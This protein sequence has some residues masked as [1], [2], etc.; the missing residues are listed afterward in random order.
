MNVAFCL[1][2]AALAV[3]LALT[4]LPEAAKSGYSEAAENAACCSCWARGCW[5]AGSWPEPNASISDCPSTSSSLCLRRP[6]RAGPERKLPGVFPTRF[7]RIDDWGAAA[8]GADGAGWTS[9]SP[10][11]AVNLGRDSDE[12]PGAGF[13]PDDPTVTLTVLTGTTG[14]LAE[15]WW[16][17]DGD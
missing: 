12:P 10:E 2:R 14:V 15:P 7:T 1:R 13:C 16:S 6:R 9:R 11:R 4:G 5:L 17:A 3:S 8:G